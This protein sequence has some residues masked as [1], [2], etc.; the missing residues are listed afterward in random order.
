METIVYPYQKNPLALIIGLFLLFVAFPMLCVLLALPVILVLNPSS[1]QS[2]VGSRQGLLTALGMCGLALLVPV[3]IGGLI[4]AIR[5][6]MEAILTGDTFSYGPRGRLT[7]IRLAEV[8]RISAKTWF[9]SEDLDWMITIESVDRRKISFSPGGGP[10]RR[11]Y[12]AGFD[13]QAIL[14]DV[15][16]RLPASAQVDASV[17][18][19]AETGQVV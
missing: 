15:L 10:L 7:T 8:A 1:V 12:R 3:F 4:Y 14:R 13:Y 18:H 5:F 16:P 19:F 6:R 2:F 9:W 17:R 11:I